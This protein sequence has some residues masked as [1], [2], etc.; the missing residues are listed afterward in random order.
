MFDLEN[1][2]FKLNL[3]FKVNESIEDEEIES[4]SFSINGVTYNVDNR[5]PLTMTL[6]EYLRDV[7]GMTG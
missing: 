6:N 1:P 5:Y 4:I 2:K 7:L 3:N